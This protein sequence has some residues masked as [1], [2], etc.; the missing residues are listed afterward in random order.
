MGGR[1]KFYWGFLP[2]YLIDPKR[3]R[4][5]QGS[6]GKGFGRPFGKWSKRKERVKKKEWGGR[7][8][9]VEGI[10][11]GA[12]SVVSFFLSLFFL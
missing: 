12:V 3:Q 8:G 10:A 9:G 11:E 5:N 1:K 4:E 2:P 6:W 7:W